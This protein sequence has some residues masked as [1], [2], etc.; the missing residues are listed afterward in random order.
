MLCILHQVDK[1][2]RIVPVLLAAREECIRVSG[3]LVSTGRSADSMHKVLGGVWEIIV[4]LDSGL[5][6]TG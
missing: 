1:V 3:G 4:D 6:Y 2:R 5:A